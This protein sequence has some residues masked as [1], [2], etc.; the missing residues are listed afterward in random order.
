MEICSTSS[1]K[2]KTKALLPQELLLRRHIVDNIH[3]DGWL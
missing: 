2:G 3:R 1:E